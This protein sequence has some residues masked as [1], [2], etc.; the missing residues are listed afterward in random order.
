M[1]L[2]IR[3]EVN[4]SFCFAVLIL[5]HRKTS[6]W[7]TVF[8]I[9]LQCIANPWLLTTSCMPLYC[10]IDMQ[11]AFIL[12]S[13]NQTFAGIATFFYQL[14]SNGPFAKILAPKTSLQGPLWQSGP[15]PELDI[16]FP[17]ISFANRLN[18]NIGLTA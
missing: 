17:A 9:A 18:Q 8:E 11:G 5:S 7:L 10:S 3:K 15:Q 4:P 2:N 16:K 6:K 13:G 1:T 14:L 12:V